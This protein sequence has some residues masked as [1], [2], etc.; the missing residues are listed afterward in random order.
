MKYFHVLH[1]VVQLLMEFPFGNATC[2]KIED[3]FSDGGGI[4]QEITQALKVVNVRTEMKVLLMIAAFLRE[5]EV[6]SIGFCS[7]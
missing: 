5:G 2:S 6:G 4:P 1:M 7:Q 3:I